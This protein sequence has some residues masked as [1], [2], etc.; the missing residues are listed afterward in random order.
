MEMYNYLFYVHILDKY[1]FN[2]HVVTI[3]LICEIRKKIKMSI[4]PI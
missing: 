4:W 3:C 1:S 2:H